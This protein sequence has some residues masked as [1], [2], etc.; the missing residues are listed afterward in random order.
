V[1]QIRSTFTKYTKNLVAIEVIAR[2]KAA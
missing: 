1:L 2:K